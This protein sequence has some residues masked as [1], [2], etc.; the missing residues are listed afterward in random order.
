MKLEHINKKGRKLYLSILPLRKTGLSSCLLI[1][2][3]FLCTPKKCTLSIS[4]HPAQELWRQTDPILM[5]KELKKQ[6]S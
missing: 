3:K 6:E 5:A 1:F 2:N 4:V